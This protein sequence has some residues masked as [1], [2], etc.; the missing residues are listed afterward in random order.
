MKQF[1]VFL[2]EKDENALFEILESLWFQY[3]N[4]RFKNNS[5]IQGE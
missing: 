3:S 1:Y 2:S 4:W 5:E